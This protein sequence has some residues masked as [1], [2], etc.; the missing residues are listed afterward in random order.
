MT[1]KEKLELAVAALRVI[2]FEG[3]DEVVCRFHDGVDLS[4][5][6]GDTVKDLCAGLTEAQARA[7][8]KRHYPE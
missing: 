3:G 6:I 8:I 1:T 5:Y 7:I 2:T 4:N